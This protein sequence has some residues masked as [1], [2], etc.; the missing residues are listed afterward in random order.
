MYVHILCN[1]ASIEFVRVHRR[2][3]RETRRVPNSTARTVGSMREREALILNRYRYRTTYKY[4]GDLHNTR[5][6]SSM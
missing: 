1:N 6:Q 4:A 2:A 5:N 3:A